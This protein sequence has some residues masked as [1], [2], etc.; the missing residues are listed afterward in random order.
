MSM[1][2]AKWGQRVAVS[3]DRVAACPTCVEAPLVLWSERILELG[4]LESER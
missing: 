2:R 4:I 3:L 1:L